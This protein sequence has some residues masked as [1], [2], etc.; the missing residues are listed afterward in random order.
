M[1]EFELQRLPAPAPL[2][3]RLER[4]AFIS[5]HTSPTASLGRS[6]NG[7]LNVYVREVCA[8][9]AALGVACD[10]FTR[11]S[12]PE[13]P[14]SERLAPG[15]RVVYLP[16]GP[17][18]ADKYQ[19]FD[20]VEAF[21]EQVAA[22]A[23]RAGSRYDAIYSHYWLSGAAACSLRPVLRAPWIHTAHTLE[24]GRAHV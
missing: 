8:Q 19:L 5:L 3:R 7:G 10:V 22:W 18:G 16:A 9:L 11:R 13:D 14:P 17:Q 21:A 24:I 2:N 1:A 23:A 20:H 15:V 12:S 6:A 4:V